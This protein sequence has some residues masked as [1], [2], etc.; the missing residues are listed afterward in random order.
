M[1]Q[2]IGLFLVSYIL[3]HPDVVPQWMSSFEV[4]RVGVPENGASICDHAGLRHK[5]DVDGMMGHMPMMNSSM[6]HGHM[7][8]GHMMHGH[9]RDGAMMDGHKMLDDIVPHPPDGGSKSGKEKSADVDGGGK[10]LPSVDDLMLP[11]QV[12]PDVGK[13]MPKVHDSVGVQLADVLSS[14]DNKISAKR[15][16]DD[17]HRALIIPVGIQAHGGAVYH[18]HVNSASPY[19]VV[20]LNAGEYYFQ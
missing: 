3:S 8:Q 4:S 20:R 5:R 7:M 10:H 11:G 6:M 19:R 14:P 18:S 15:N 1:N 16:D 17:D 2:V 12:M 9:M 13:M